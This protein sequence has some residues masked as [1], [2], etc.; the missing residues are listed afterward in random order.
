MGDR[1]GVDHL[2]TGLAGVEGGGLGAGAALGIVGVQR[3]GYGSVGGEGGGQDD[4]V[5]DRLAGAL[6][7]IR[8]HGAGGVAGRAIRP[9]V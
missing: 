2:M 1:P 3:R 5:F 8:A 9:L 6:S 4:G 7:A